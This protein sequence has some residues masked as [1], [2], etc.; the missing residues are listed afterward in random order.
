MLL[1]VLSFFTVIDTLTVI[2]NTKTPYITEITSAGAYIMGVEPT[3][4]YILPLTKNIKT[5]FE[6]KYYNKL[7]GHVV[8]NTDD[9]F[10]IY[11]DISLTIEDLITVISHEMVHVKQ[12]QTGRLKYING[13][14]LWEGKPATLKV[15]YNKRLWEK[16]AIRYQSY[17][18]ERVKE[19]VKITNVK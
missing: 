9:T 8:K 14:I 10:V 3:T 4:I 15:D 6:K 5:I 7:R 18:S 1:L 12:L 11:V 19:I 2:D 13:K 16:E 17:I